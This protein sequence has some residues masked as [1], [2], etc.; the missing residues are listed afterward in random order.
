V[1][2]TIEQPTT[3]DAARDVCLVLLQVDL[4]LPAPKFAPAGTVAAVAQPAKAAA[5]APPSGAAA[6]APAVPSAAHHDH[7]LASV[8][9]GLRGKLCELLAVAADEIP[10][11]CARGWR[12][13]SGGRAE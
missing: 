2:Q 9:E 7:T 8:K 1:P 4:G 11:S 13:S 10:V 5:G 12:H 3:C 6:A